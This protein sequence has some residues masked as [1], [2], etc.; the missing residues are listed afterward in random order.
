MSLT[1]GLS[2]CHDCW[3]FFSYLFLFF[4][5][6]IY[7]S[8]LLM[9]RC[10]LAT[11]CS[12]FS[13]QL[14]RTQPFNRCLTYRTPDRLTVFARL[15]TFTVTVIRCSFFILQDSRYISCLWIDRFGLTSPMFLT[16]YFTAMSSGKPIRRLPQNNL[17]M[18]FPSLSNSQLVI[19]ATIYTRLPLWPSAWCQ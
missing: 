17:F 9:L 2:S 15:W 14:C 5:L 6:S 12:S 1:F 7:T 11:V 13:M 8:C 19:V 16:T 10:T 4:T 18:F 3:V